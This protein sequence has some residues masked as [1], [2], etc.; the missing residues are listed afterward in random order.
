MTTT[1]LLGATCLAL[2]VACAPALKVTPSDA[3][4]VLRSLALEAPDPGLQGPHRVLTL[5]YGSGTD[6]NRPEY[7]DSVSITTET[8]DASKLVD[9]GPSAR[10]RNSY[11]GFTPEEMPLNGR[12]S[13]PARV[14]GRRS[15]WARSPVGWRSRSRRTGSFARKAR[16]SG[17]VG[18]SCTVRFLRRA[19]PALNRMKDNPPTTRV[20]LGSRSIRR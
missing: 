5:Y 12:V 7:R 16:V 15:A 14:R 17:P 19:A 1:R 9:L 2:A 6:K 18:R 4:V 20:G 3:D 10:E 13:R 8:V 11:W